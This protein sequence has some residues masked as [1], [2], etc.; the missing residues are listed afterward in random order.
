[1]EQ[2]RREIKRLPENFKDQAAEKLSKE[3]LEIC[4]QLKDLERSVML[5]EKTK[6]KAKKMLWWDDVI[7]GLAKQSQQTDT[8]AENGK[9]ADTSTAPTNSTP[10]ATL[11]KDGKVWFIHPISLFKFVTYQDL[12]DVERFLV[13]YESEHKNFKKVD[14]DNVPDFNQK[15]KYTLR[16]IIERINLFYRKNNE[17]K[18]N[19]YY[20]SY[21]LATARW[22]ATWGEDV[23]CALF[24]HGSLSYFNQYDPVLAS[25]SGQREKAIKNGNTKKGDGYK[26]RGRGLAHLTWKKN[27]KDASDYFGIDFV[28]DPDKAAELDNAVPILIWGT[29]TGGFSEQKITKYIYKNH[30]DYKAA[31]KVINGSNYDDEVASFAVRFE[32]ILRQTSIL[33]EEF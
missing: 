29:M 1:M 23:F 9:G 17:F 11:S 32:A 7:K 22:E 26:Y 14:T 16:G 20:L 21:M 3:Q 19:I 33:T 30:I 8:T 18:P 6:E 4:V 28:K 2:L 10:P 31:R 24:E 13:M 5:W 25:T 27:Y 15:S 12:I